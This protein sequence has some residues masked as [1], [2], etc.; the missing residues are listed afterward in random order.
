MENELTKKKNIFKIIG[1]VVITCVVGLSV[2]YAAFYLI[3]TKT[4]KCKYEQD[5]GDGSVMK[6]NT[7]QKFRNE[8]LIHIHTEQIYD[9]SKVEEPGDYGKTTVDAI[10]ET[11]TKTCKEEEGC[12]YSVNDNGKEVKF[13]LDR[14]FDK[15]QRE[16]WALNNDYDEY[17]KGYNDLCEDNKNGS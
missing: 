15:A 16:K 10:N 5:V 9:Y 2:A 3:T 17:I 11:F 12:T 14:K 4:F 13:V 6:M 8:K 1:I 7:V